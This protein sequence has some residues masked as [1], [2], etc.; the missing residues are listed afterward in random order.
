MPVL[1]WFRDFEAGHRE[2]EALPS[3]PELRRFLRGVRAWP[4]GGFE[5]HSTNPRYRT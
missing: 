1:R 5:W 4:G 2:L 3:P